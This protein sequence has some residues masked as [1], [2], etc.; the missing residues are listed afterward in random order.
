M[1]NLTAKITEAFKFNREKFLCGFAGRYYP[2]KTAV[3]S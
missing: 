3:V 1:V 2:V